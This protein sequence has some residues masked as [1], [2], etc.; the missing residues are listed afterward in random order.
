M[1]IVSC[2]LNQTCTKQRRLRAHFSRRQ[3]TVIAERGHGGGWWSPLGLDAPQT[4]PLRFFSC[5]RELQ[6]IRRE[7]V[8]GVQQLQQLQFL[9]LV[10][11][12]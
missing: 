10:R 12:Q 11:W 5:Q 6:Q 8:P 7:D 9:F 1:V 2:T 4:A 3:A